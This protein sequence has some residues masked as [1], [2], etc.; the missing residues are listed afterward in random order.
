[1]SFGAIFVF[2]VWQ[3][4]AWKLEKRAR[5]ELKHGCE[6]FATSMLQGMTVQAASLFH[7]VPPSTSTAL[8]AAFSCSTMQLP[9]LDTSQARVGNLGC[10][11]CL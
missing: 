4:Y 11:L 3:A 5:E 1:M 6:M 2:G 9:H 8:L 10:C 7:W